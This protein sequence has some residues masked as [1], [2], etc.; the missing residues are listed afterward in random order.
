MTIKRIM[1]DILELDPESISDS[2]SMDHTGSW[3]SLAHINLMTALEQEFGVALE[4]DEIESM[5]SFS[6][7]RTVLQRKLLGG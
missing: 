7:I 1:A 3:D 4:I 5:R 2:T 6:H